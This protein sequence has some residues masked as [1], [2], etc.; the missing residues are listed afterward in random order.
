MVDGFRPPC[1]FTTLRQEYLDLHTIEDLPVFHAVIPRVETPS[2][3]PSIDCLYLSSN[4]M[5]KDISTKI[6]VCPLAWWWHLFQLRGYTKHIAKSLM[7]CLK[8]N[9]S[10]VAHMS[11]FDQSMGSVT[12]Q[13]ANTDDFLDR[14]ENELGS[15]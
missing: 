9:C 12:T 4:T 13:F 11:T 6:V 10:A 8:A 14:V 7:D 1:K 2:C 5:A 3:G 15:Y